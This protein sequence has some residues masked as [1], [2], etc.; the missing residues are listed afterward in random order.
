MSMKI[1]HKQ[2]CSLF[3][4]KTGELLCLLVLFFVSGVLVAQDGIATTPAVTFL[5][6]SPTEIT[7]PA[8]AQALAADILN[9]IDPSGTVKQGLSLDIAPWS[10]IPGLRITLQDYQQDAKKYMLANTQVSVATIKST[11]SV[12]DTDLGIG[13]RVTLLD[14]SDFLKDIDYMGEL[15]RRMDEG[16]KQPEQPEDITEYSQ[17]LDRVFTEMV[18]EWQTEHQISNWNRN[19]LSMAF[20]TGL[21]LGDSEIDQVEWIGIGTWMTGALKLRGW[22]QLTGQAKYNYRRENLA[23]ELDHILEASVRTLAGGPVFTVSVEYSSVVNFSELESDWY[24]DR[25]T[26]AIE[27]QVGEGMWLS[28]GIGGS[29]SDPDERVSLLSS[30]RWKIITGPNLRPPSEGNGQ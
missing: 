19:A 24:S 7:R 30:L 12:N 25:L 22:G 18:E 1:K 29:I 5:G 2:D 21:R 6:A 17:C 23:E 9:A 3:S 11:G 15:D 16:C 8:T 13:F 28:S 10:L 14:D 27:Y 26:V 20:A 4:P